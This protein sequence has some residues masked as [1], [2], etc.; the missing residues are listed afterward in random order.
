MDWLCAS[1]TNQQEALLVTLL[2]LTVPLADMDLL[3]HRDACL[4]L[5]LPY[6]LQSSPQGLESAVFQMAATLTTQ[7]EEQKAHRLLQ[8]QERNQPTLPFQKF[9]V[10][11]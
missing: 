9:G 2:P 4:N 7:T 1:V 10:L 6:H 11:T 5:A 3:S 8:A